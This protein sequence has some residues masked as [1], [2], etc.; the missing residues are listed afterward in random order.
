[1]TLQVYRGACND[2][3]VCALGYGSQLVPAV[4]TSRGVPLADAS[5]ALRLTAS[6]LESAAAVTRA[7]VTSEEQRSKARLLNDWEHWAK[8]YPPSL[9]PSMQYCTP[10]EVLAF[11]EYWREH[12]PGRLPAG[13]TPLSEG[14][15]VP[16]APS[17]LRGVKHRL[18]AICSAM[19][20]HGPWGEDRLN[21]NPC[22][23][24]RVAKYLDGYERLAFEEHGYSPSGAVPM[25]LSKF[26]RLVAH[27]DAAMGPADEYQRCMLL[28]DKVAFAYMWECGQRGKEAGRLVVSD[29]AYECVEVTPAWPDLV[30][31]KVESDLPLL[32]ESS[33]GTKKRK[34]RHPGVLYLAKTLQPDGTGLLVATLPVYA[35]AMEQYGY[36]LTQWLLRPGDQPAGRGTFLQMPYT[37]SALGHRLRGYLE[38][39][40]EYQGETTYS[41]RRGSTQQASSRGLS[42]EAIAQQRLWATTAS[43][44]LYRHPTRHVLRLPAGAGRPAGA[45]EPGPPESSSKA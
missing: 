5:V 22:L 28:R 14:H 11:L 17:T 35:A 26:W 43:V 24:P 18:S 1:M 36:P 9:R 32:V 3:Y 30:R 6:R 40:G 38:A 39:M 2:V 13:A 7:G 45:S 42:D 8:A 37:T 10:E 41:L 21:G 19:G 29:F 44:R 16:C 25:G 27:V 34:S 4:G 31:G 12:H 23:S 33:M 20:R 15:I